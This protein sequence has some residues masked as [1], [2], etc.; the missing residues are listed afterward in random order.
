[1]KIKNITLLHLLWLSLVLGLPGCG[2]HDA[3]GK[4]EHGKHADKT[5]EAHALEGEKITV[6]TST[7]ELFLEALPLVRGQ[8]TTVAAHFTRL[9]DFKPITAGAVDVLLSGGNAPEERFAVV[10]PAEPGIYQPVVTP[11]QVGERSLTLVLHTPEG[12][13]RHDAGLIRV[14]ASAAEAADA[15]EHH[16]EGIVFTKEQQWKVDFATA[17]AIKGVARASV[18][19]NGTLRGR[20]DGDAQLAA[21]VTGQVN[22]AGSFPHIGMRVKRGQVL[23]Y[24]APRLGG[25]VDYA[26]LEVAVT[27]AR[28]VYAQA[29]RERER[30]ELLFAQEAVA[31]K[32]KLAAQAAEQVAAADLDAATRRLGQYGGSRGGG[33][34]IRSP[35]DGVLADVKAAPG[36]YVQEGMPLFH[37]A[38]TRNLWLEVQIPESE[39]AQLGTPGGVW[40]AVDGREKP[41]EFEVGKNARLI[42]VGGAVDATT[43]TVPVIFEFANPDQT[44]RLGQ[45]VKAHVR[46]AAEAREAVLVPATALQDENGMAVVYVQIGGDSFERR[47]VTPGVRDGAMVEIRNGLDAGQRVVSKGAYLIRLST[48]KAGASGHAGHAH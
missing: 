4:D 21:P 46:A 33:M 11:R 34:P 9:A 44:L 19:G 39:A 26:A 27:K 40:F 42:A 17:E 48:A 47:I 20:Y 43:R 38:D 1:M 45:L 7:T 25:D 36:G 3:G 16:A 6:F 37:I 12:E 13:V 15:P 18:A 31:E 29:Q 14:Y 2:G 5:G 28:I 22:A 8:A 35:I 32:R 30:M 24:L 41:Y 23:A 10:A